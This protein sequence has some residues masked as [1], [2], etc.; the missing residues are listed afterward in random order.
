[1]R[2]PP[3]SQRTNTRSSQASPRRARPKPSYLSDSGAAPS[4]PSVHAQACGSSRRA[5]ALPVASD[6][7]A[8]CGGR[9]RRDQFTPGRAPRFVPRPDALSLHREHP[10]RSRDGAASSS[11]VHKGRRVGKAH[12]SGEPVIES[13][14]PRGRA[15]PGAGE[16]E[17][18]SGRR[19][20]ARRA[21]VLQVGGTGGVGRTRIGAQ[22]WFAGP[23]RRAGGG[24]VVTPAARMG[25]ACSPRVSGGGVPRATGR[26]A[27]PGHWSPGL[28]TGRRGSARPRAVDAISSRRRLPTAR[29][30]GTNIHG[31][32]GRSGCRTARHLAARVFPRAPPRHRFIHRITPRTQRDATNDPHVESVTPASSRE[33]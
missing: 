27:A 28:H 23:I 15:R 11:N 32:P 22:G 31:S 18:W 21:D 6:E 24:V 12:H 1:M 13:S 19:T 3:P 14:L 30:G 26:G 2:G 4:A 17:D 10:G 8:R 25:T 5:R 7:P 33:S 9:R 20:Q 29:A 16:G